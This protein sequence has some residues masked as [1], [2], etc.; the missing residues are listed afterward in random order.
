MKL[1]HTRGW[2]GILVLAICAARG[3]GQTSVLYAF[4]GDAAGD[5]CG[6]SVASAGDVDGDGTNDIVV[7]H[8]GAPGGSYAGRVR[9]YSGATGAVLF[10]LEGGAPGDQFGASV[11]GAGDVNGDGFADIIVGAPN[12]NPAGTDSG[13]AKV[14]AGPSGALLYT[15]TGA[16]AL[17]HF[18]CSVSGAGDLNGDGHAD[19]VIGA[20]G[21]DTNG[22]DSGSV[23][24]YSGL[25]GAQMFVFNGTA[26]GDW[27][28]F[29]VDGG[30][31]LNNDGVPDIVIGA[32]ASDM[33]G[34]YSGS[35]RGISG[36]TGA[37][38]FTVAGVGGTFGVSPGDLMGYS[39]AF[40]GHVNNDAFADVVAGR[41]GSSAGNYGG[42][43]L[44][45]LAGPSGTTL[46]NVA[47]T[48]LLEGAGYSVSGVG[49]VNG[50]GRDDF[51][52][53]SYTASTAPAPGVAR[54]YS[55]AN[56]AVLYTVTGGSV[57]GDSFGQSV[58]GLG[59]LNA[60]GRREV[61]IGAPLADPNGSG[62]GILR[63]IT[64]LPLAQTS[65]LGTGCGGTSV[66]PALSSTLPRIGQS[67]TLTILSGPPGA[68][69]VVAVSPPPSA[70]LSLGSGC[71]VFVDPAALTQIW[72][73]MLSATGGASIALAVPNLSTL[74]GVQLVAQG[75]FPGTTGPLGFHLT[76][77][78][79]LT[80]GY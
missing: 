9:V 37:V 45:V 54:V 10:T 77:G 8:Y 55:G 25:T 35:V 44:R 78:R 42:G 29:A 75:I 59:D 3:S 4:T 26:A 32:P 71:T 62:S 30:G 66:Q 63:V 39:V 2:F 43:G 60:D 64:L 36:A 1:V 61:A 65:A 56:A 28:G 80:L 27:F 79:L 73:P 33:G 11:D 69:G 34:D 72:A 46:F 49:D 74:A 40:A 13:L 22:T 53:G 19:V 5:G 38:L 67:V 50:D 15:L 17:D 16:A 57:A 70:P 41:P 31:D 24:V 48:M 6:S 23:K 52:A 58:A 12:A 68:S 76:S 7:G 20:Y 47:G 18:G 21:A 51:I 14:F